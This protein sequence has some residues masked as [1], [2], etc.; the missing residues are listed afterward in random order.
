MFVEIKKKTF[1]NFHLVQNHG[2]CVISFS[3]T[4]KQ[5]SLD[6]QLLSLFFDH[7]FSANEDASRNLQTNLSKGFLP[8]PPFDED[9]SQFT[10]YEQSRDPTSVTQASRSNISARPS[11]SPV[12]TTSALPQ[13]PL[14]SQPIHTP[15]EPSVSTLNRS[16]RRTA[17]KHIKTQPWSPEDHRIV[18]EKNTKKGNKA[19]A[20]KVSGSKMSKSSDP[21]VSATAAL[22]QAPLSSQT[23]DIPKEPSAS[24][25][26][27][28]PRRTARIH[29]KTQPCMP[30]LPEDQH[31][32]KRNKNNKGNDDKAM[33][34]QV[35]GSQMS[36]SSDLP[37]AT[38]TILPKAP[39]SVHIQ[40][41][42][43]TSAS[44]RLSTENTNPR[45]TTRLTKPTQPYSPE[46]E[47]DF[48][49]NKIKKGNNDKEKKE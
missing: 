46:V 48:K 11:D 12:E 17:R 10:Q 21:L 15:K 40:K 13:A 34:T 41:E 14:S 26:N 43:S 37:V 1:D 33:A 45:R 42:P 20:T 2:K 9:E 3:F 38:T 22:S 18:K 7:F 36:N 16:P 4:F 25:V 23:V 29:K 44:I 39:L 27:R 35:S 6:D 30:C 19:M 8:I 28:S 49:K 24:T 32:V 47:N 5:G 31:D